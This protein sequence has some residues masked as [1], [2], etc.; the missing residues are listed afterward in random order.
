MTAWDSHGLP[1]EEPSRAVRHVPQSG[2]SCFQ[3]RKERLE[4]WQWE[5]EMRVAKNGTSAQA[6]L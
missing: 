1:H 5:I 3:F 2:R 6:K 4:N